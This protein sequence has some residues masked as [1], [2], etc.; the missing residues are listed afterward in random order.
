[1]LNYL[2]ELLLFAGKAV[3]VVLTIGAV[4]LVLVASVSSLKHKENAKAGCSSRSSSQIVLVNLSRRKERQKK[5]LQKML[6]K[7]DPDE[8]LK[9]EAEDDKKGGLFS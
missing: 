7:I 1:M 2:F 8:R 3:I 5:Q 9:R 6:K 4:L